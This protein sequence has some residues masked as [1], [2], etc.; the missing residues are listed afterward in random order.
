MV[1][2]DFITKNYIFNKKPSIKEIIDFIANYDS[3]FFDNDREFC[4]LFDNI[5]INNGYTQNSLPS[6]W[7]I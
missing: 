7:S 1:E 5:A 3:S 4:Y 6:Y 2:M